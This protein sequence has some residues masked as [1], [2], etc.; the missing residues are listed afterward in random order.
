GADLQEMPA[1]E[2]RSV[3][4]LLGRELDGLV[5][6]AGPVELFRVFKIGPDRRTRR[7]ADEEGGH[8]EGIGAPGRRWASML[9]GFD[10]A[11]LPSETAGETR[12]VGSIIGRRDGRSSNVLLASF[13][14]SS[15][16]GDGVTGLFPTARANSTLDLDIGVV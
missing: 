10:H 14:K 3:V 1:L 8:P 15:R 7:E 6:A 13:A 9:G 5:I 16:P 2:P 4:D 11:S 12:A